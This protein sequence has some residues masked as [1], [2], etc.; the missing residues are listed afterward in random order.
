[1]NF[2]EIVPKQRINQE[3]IHQIVSLMPSKHTFIAEL[4]CHVC[5]YSLQC[6]FH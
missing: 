1:M 5:L 6:L 3:G 2:N 4:N